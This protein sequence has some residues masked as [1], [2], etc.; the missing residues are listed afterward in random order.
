MTRRFQAEL[1]VDCRNEVGESCFWDPRDG[2]LYW[3]DIESR[4]I[5]RRSEAGA[6][7]TF[8]LPDR[9]GFI[10]PRR[11]SGFVL[12]FPKRI[13]VAPP[14][15]D[16]FETV[17][18][19]ETDIPWIRTNDAAVDPQ[20]GIVFGSCNEHPDRDRRQATA[21]FHRVGPNGNL[22]RLFGGCFTCNG[23]AFSTDNETMYLT[24]TNE[25][26]IRRFSFKRGFDRLEEL[27]PLASPE[28][29]DGKPDGSKIDSAD[30]CW[31]AR[32]W[33]YNIACITPEGEVAANVSVPAKGPT[34]V[35]FGGSDLKD[36]YITSLRK[37]HT[38]DELSANPQ[39]GGLYKARVDVSGRDQ[40][41]CRL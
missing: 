13:V 7:R 26:T 29:A 15:L 20:G 8:D 28:V 34:C 16:S 38:R 23:I 17:C 4:I 14:T 37:S 27:E 36:L 9:A 25:G 22:Q 33:A 2:A 19:V 21:G 1:V 39:A 30:C 32:V 31:N 40:L 12:G 18:T 3:T 6:V 35:A 41:M 11:Q 5:F 24:D 10:L